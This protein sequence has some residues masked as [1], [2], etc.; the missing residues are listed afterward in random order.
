MRTLLLSLALAVPA[1]A[2]PWLASPALAQGT[3]DAD[4]DAR[5]QVHFHAG[6]DYY[7]RGDYENALEELTLAYD[8]SHRPELLYDLG[9]CHER[10]GHWRQA[11]DLYDEYLAAVPDSEH[12]AVVRERAMRLRAREET[13][14]PTEPTTPIAPSTPAPIAPAIPDAQ[15]TSPHPAAFAVL[16]A[17]AVGLAVFGVLGGLALAEDGALASEC[18]TACAPSRVSTL[19]SFTIGAD[20]SLGIGAALAI[21][22]LVLVFTTTDG[23]GSDS[24]GAGARLGVGPTG[25]TLSG[26][27]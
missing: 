21:T 8:M 19:E 17:G 9:S 6:H 27:F 5:A 7:E 24:E 2:S 10:M 23:G 1:L 12:A 25:V 16:G 4:L 20:V 18:G 11:A 22:G 15:A 13:D 3:T 14:A 26:Q